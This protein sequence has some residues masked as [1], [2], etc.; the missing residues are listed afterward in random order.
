MSTTMMD[1]VHT[2][3]AF[4][5]G[6]TIRQPTKREKFMHLLKTKKFRI[7]ALLVSIGTIG[8]MARNRLGS[9]NGTSTQ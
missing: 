8:A 1:R 9:V 6:L 7:P 5:T 4:V 2:A 3:S